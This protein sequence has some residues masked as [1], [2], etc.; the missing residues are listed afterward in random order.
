VSVHFSLVRIQAAPR[1]ISI[2]IIRDMYSGDYMARIMSF[3]TVVFILVPVI[4]P[5]LGKLIMT[6]YDWQGIFYVQVIFSIIVAIWFWHRQ[7]ET[8][9]RNLRWLT[10]LSLGLLWVRF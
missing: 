2:A 6:Q 5:A 8:L 1:T 4:A 9:F 7:P 3:I 10:R